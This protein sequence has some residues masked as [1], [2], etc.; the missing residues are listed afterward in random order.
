MYQQI[1]IEEHAG[2]Y[3]DKNSSNFSGGYTAGPML[4][5]GSLGDSG[6]GAARFLVSLGLRVII[7]PYLEYLL[8]HW[9]DRSPTYVPPFSRNRGT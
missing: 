5:R 1:E 6:P 7:H 9:R 2:S 8:I 3:L 4:R